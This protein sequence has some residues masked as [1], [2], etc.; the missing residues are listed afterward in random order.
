M[1]FCIKFEQGCIFLH[2]ENPYAPSMA[3]LWLIEL[4]EGEP[5]KKA[6]TGSIRGFDYVKYKQAAFRLHNV[7]ESG[8]WLTKHRH[9]LE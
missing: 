8:V 3:T 2:I 6:S 9:D 7:A 1:E 4:P 5:R